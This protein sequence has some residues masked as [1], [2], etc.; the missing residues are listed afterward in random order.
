ML[1]F[2]DYDKAYN[3][4][5]DTIGKMVQGTTRQRHVKIIAKPALLLAVIKLI[6][7]R[8]VTDNKFFY[9]DVEEVYKNVFGSKFI[10]AQQENLTPLAYPFYYLQSQGFWHIAW[11][12]HGE[13]KTESPGPAWL[14]RNAQ[15]AYL[16]PE[17]WLLLQSK[18]HRD[19]LA[20]YII[21]EKI[22][23]KETTGPDL[24]RRI[25][26]LLIAV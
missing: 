1:R 5:A 7:S 17:L 12:P 13:E 2:F 21:S 4:Y 18:T 14:R 10:A 19:R 15:Y 24:L 8:K 22:L 23:H 9:E 3:Y 26:S 20:Q 25:L 16:D 11:Q 6:E